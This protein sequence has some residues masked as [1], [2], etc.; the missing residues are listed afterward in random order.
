MH[1]PLT[2][3]IFYLFFNANYNLFVDPILSKQPR[4]FARRAPTTT[5]TITTITTN[6]TTNN[7]TCYVPK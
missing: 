2:V 1:F 6:A 5:I 3:I 7:T 4:K